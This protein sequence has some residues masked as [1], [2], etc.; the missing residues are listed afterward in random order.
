MGLTISNNITSYLYPCVISGELYA[1]AA[2]LC[3]SVAAVFYKKGIGAV[4]YRQC[5]THILC[6]DVC[7]GNVPV[8]PRWHFDFTLIG[9][10]FLNLGD[11]CGS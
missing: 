4:R 10:A 9:F 5:D 7:P 3:W 6:N 2:A 11:C 1:L 8:H